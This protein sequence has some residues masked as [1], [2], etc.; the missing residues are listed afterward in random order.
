[1]ARHRS[2]SRSR[3]KRSRS[4][5]KDAQ[6]K[7][8]KSSSPR[9]VRARSQSPRRIPQKRARSSSPI[10]S[11]SK[12][13]KLDSPARRTSKRSRSPEPQKS[14][15]RKKEAETSESEQEQLKFPETFRKEEG[16]LDAN[17]VHELKF[18]DRV[19]ASRWSR[20]KGINGKL[21]EQVPLLP[22]LWNQFENWDLRCLA[23]GRA[24]YVNITKSFKET[25]MIQAFIWQLRKTKQAGTTEM[26]D[27][28]SIAE[29][30]ANKE[31]KAFK[32][33]Q[34]KRKVYEDMSTFMLQA[35][36]DK[37]PPETTQAADLL[38]TIKQQQEEIDKLKTATPPSKKGPGT[39]PDSW[40]KT[41]L[42]EKEEAKEQEED[43]F[44]TF[45][46]GDKEAY[47]GTQTKK[48]SG[49]GLETLR[50]GSSP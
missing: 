20:S 13:H 40:K 35:L 28:E 42:P 23:N 7:R 37:L 49:S 47:L 12:R 17:A 38:A 15:K 43:P 31:K 1:M 26:I 50:H 45:S 46:K 6:K 14:A 5:R 33:H 21:V 36:M 34:D 44:K 30:W 27:I 22:L 48:N 18:P 8:D 4:R 41:R 19:R 16:Y 11:S 29:T 39:L 10:P 3:A 9:R 2:R 24:V 25:Q 32:S